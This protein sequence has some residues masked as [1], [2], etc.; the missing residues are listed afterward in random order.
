MLKK[1]VVLA[2]SMLPF[3]AYAQNFKFG[4]VDS[5]E[6]FEA[7]PERNTIQTELDALNEKYEKEI[8]KMGEE[9]QRKVTDFINSQ[10]S[11]PENIRQRRAQEINE[12]EQRIQNFRQV[13][14]Q[15]FQ[16][17]QQQKLQPVF[18]K[19]TNA[20][21]AVGEEQGFTYIFD[22]GN[23]GVLY[24]NESTTINVLPLVKTKLGIK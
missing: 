9:Y 24:F 21:K 17:Q 20:I 10:D 8:Q 3:L 14:S 1:L 19:I 13:A 4:N 2:I 6:I 5:A 15:D 12:L 16:Q 18:E 22:L 7:M 23:S 11:L